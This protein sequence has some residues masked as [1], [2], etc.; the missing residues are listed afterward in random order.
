MGH[1]GDGLRAGEAATIAGLVGS[2][3]VGAA[4]VWERPHVVRVTL[5]DGR[6]VITKRPR[7]DPETDQTTTRSRLGFGREADVLALLA[8][9]P[10]SPAPAFMG[11]VGDLLVMEDLP[12]GRSLA[13]L[14]L[15][16]GPDEA[17]RGV[18]AYAVA[19]ARF[20]AAAATVGA[21]EGAGGVAA[22]QPWWADVTDAGVD[23][24]AA[25]VG[26]SGVDGDVDPAAVARE[27]HAVA[28]ALR[29][30]G[31]WRTLVHG[32]AC[33]DNTRIE[34]GPSGRFR[35]FDF[36]L[37]SFGSC[38]LDASSLVAP[39]PTCWCF[40]RVPDEVAA[41]AVSAY[42]SILGAV[43]PEA[44]DDDEWNVALATALASWFVGRGEVIT[45]LF[46]EDRTWGTTTVRVRVRRWLEAFLGV[47]SPSGPYPAL[48]AAATAL[49][50]R[51]A[52]DWP[53]STLGDY[54]ALRTDGPGGIVGIPDFWKP[55]L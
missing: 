28:D 19:L 37:S 40:G 11:R 7:R 46:D 8:E 54:P 45:R 20:H 53:A 52:V 55:G 34:D 39:F 51:L 3:V 49:A 4:V 1:E 16:G 22:T 30:D 10:D 36:E 18:V 9:V 6:T 50:D 17:R 42:R 35:L 47:A 41:E 27:G 26:R 21:G 2:A 12:P 33:P 25:L 24:F 44:L 38:L 15:T 32:D 23:G 13:E 48:H 29:A 31:W 14:L 43:R 5:E